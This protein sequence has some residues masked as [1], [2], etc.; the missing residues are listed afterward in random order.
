MCTTYVLMLIHFYDYNHMAKIETKSG[1]SLIH[2]LD[3]ILSILHH[4]FL[5]P[6]KIVFQE[7]FDIFLFVKRSV[8]GGRW[9]AKLTHCQRLML[10]QITAL[11][12]LCLAEQADYIVS[13]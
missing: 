12:F 8:F 1:L 7:I 2:P 6:F 13:A 11:A 10:S 5:E 3:T 9:S 4:T